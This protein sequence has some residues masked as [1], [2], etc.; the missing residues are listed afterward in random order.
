M[1]KL[2]I[3]VNFD[4]LKSD[5]L[6]LSKIGRREDN[7]IYRPAFSEDDF[8]ARNWLLEKIKHSGL[9]GRMDQAGNVFGRLQGD[10]DEAAV[11]CG[12]HLDTVPGGGALDGALGV[13]V[14]LESLRRIKELDL[15]H[16]HPLEMIGFSDEE[17]RFGGSLGSQAVA[18]HL[19]REKIETASDLN[20]VTLLD[21]MAARGL[22]GHEILKATRES[23]SIRNFLELH[24]EQGPVL[25]EKQK[26]IGL[27]ETVVGLF[28]WRC[29]F[30]GQADHAGTT[31][32][33]MR[34]DALR[35]LSAFIN[36]IDLLLEKHG[37]PD[38]VLTVGRVEL[39]PGSANVVPG[40]VFF[41][42]D[43]RDRSDALLHGLQLNIEKTLKTIAS[44]HRLDFE[45]EKL[46]LIQPVN[47]STGLTN[48]LE[49]LAT[50]MG[51]STHR[52]VSGAAHDAQMMAKIAPVAI[53]FVPSVNGRSH[54]P[55]EYTNWADIENGANLT[56]RALLEMSR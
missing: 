11:L 14:A 2:D 26:N 24:I 18:G 20:G 29:V 44:Q 43:V 32:M 8:T 42:L 54:S 25:E 30:R 21:A 28:K 41:S 10:N 56:L 33:P 27:V 51:L 35:G 15:K 50:E 37:S 34:R 53:V 45:Y 9:S 4:R 49:K 16:S 7:G 47:C 12:S 52:M 39:T 40:E 23:R 46:S 38:S 31:P 3:V 22:N 48:M 5:L 6:E 1:H 36:Q 19:D 17:G 13:I 55:L